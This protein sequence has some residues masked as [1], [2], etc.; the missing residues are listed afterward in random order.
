M[1]HMHTLHRR[2]AGTVLMLSVLL[3]LPYDTDAAQTRGSSV[4]DGQGVRTG[5]YR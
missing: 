2:I 4:A 5:S 3:L 1:T